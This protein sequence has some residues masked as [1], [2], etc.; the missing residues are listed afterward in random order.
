MELGKYKSF[1]SSIIHIQHV[2]VS[3]QRHSLPY[4]LHLKIYQMNIIII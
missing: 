2:G 4:Y 3:I 1:A